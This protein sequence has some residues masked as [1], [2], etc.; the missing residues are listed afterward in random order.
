[1]NNNTLNQE[2]N[3][4]KV[5]ADNLLSEANLQF[6]EALNSCKQALDI[7]LEIGNNVVADLISSVFSQPQIPTTRDTEDSKISKLQLNGFTGMTSD[8]PIVKPPK[9]RR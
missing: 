9:R 4:R 5:E 8:T 2:W 3:N 7:Y 1:M 6:Q